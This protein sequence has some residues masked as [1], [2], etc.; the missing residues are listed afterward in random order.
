VTDLGR[1]LLGTLQKRADTPA[2]KPAS[3][4]VSG[5]PMDVGIHLPDSVPAAAAD[6]LK[7]RLRTYL[8]ALSSEFGL[9]REPV[10]TAA[11]AGSDPTEAT[12]SIDQRPVAHLRTD[13]L[14]PEDVAESLDNSVMSRILRRLSLL[15]DPSIDPRSTSAYLMMLGCRVPPGTSADS[16]DVEAAERL[17]DDQPDDHIVLEVAA[18]TMRRLHGDE[19]RAMVELREAE[20]RERGVVYPDVRVEPTDDRPGSVRLRLND[21]TLP[22]RR[23]GEHA[24]WIDVVHYLHA[25]LA[26]RRHWFVRMR[27]V[28]DLMDKDLAYVFPDLV[29]V[30]EANYTR[31]QITA[32]VRELVRGGRRMRNIPRILWLTLEAG[33]GFP[34]GSDILRLSESPLL[35]KV[36]HRP[37]ADRDPVVQAV[38][39]RKLAAEEEWRL[40]NYRPLRHAVR[41]HPE[42]EERLLAKD[43]LEALARAEWAAVRAFAKAPEAEHVFTQTVGALGPVRAAL[44]AVE[45]VP[46]VISS[47]ELPPDADVSAFPVLGDPEQDR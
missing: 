46:R 15:A 24:G 43:G 36:R 33:G 25:E 29:A 4:S 12:L 42:I 6:D 38:R 5:E 11:V 13:H 41:L 17:I 19:A 21:V 30:A 37:S 34:A 23:L 40:G 35:P 28:S 22:V 39:V 3:G 16:F 1:R 2:P 31:A 7:A 27:Q 45:K 44:Q 20:F 47:H 10:I 18:P 32:C 14:R 26:A 9:N 8:S